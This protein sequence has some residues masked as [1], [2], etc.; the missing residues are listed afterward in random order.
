MPTAQLEQR[1]AP[2][3]EYD[4]APHEEQTTDATDDAYWP[5]T[6]PAQ[7]VDEVAPVALRYVPEG[8]LTQ[9]PEPVLDWKVPAEHATHAVAPVDAAY[10]PT[11]QERHSD[12]A[13]LDANVPVAQFEQVAEPD[14]ANDPAAQMTQA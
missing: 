2:A 13:G 8:Q 9:L 1:P 12:A 10:D 4:P 3:P 14:A 7:S 11:E 5:A 6:Q